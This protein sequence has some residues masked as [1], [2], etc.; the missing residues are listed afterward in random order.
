MGCHACTLHLAM[1][2]W[3]DKEGSPPSEIATPLGCISAP[4]GSMIAV[5]TIAHAHHVY[6]TC[7][8][9]AACTFG[10]TLLGALELWHLCDERESVGGVARRGSYSK[11]ATRCTVRCY[12][13]Y[14]RGRFGY[15]VRTAYGWRSVQVHCCTLLPL[16]CC[17]S[18]VT[19]TNFAI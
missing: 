17:T 18:I 1:G 12:V 16:N 13:W 15:G 2:R 7:T 19:C 8:L 14:S 10:A 9:T 11:L 6:Y 5:C 4:L 3:P